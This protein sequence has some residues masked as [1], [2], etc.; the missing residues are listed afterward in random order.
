MTGVLR[1]S[2]SSPPSSSQE[3][4]KVIGVIFVCLG[5]ICMLRT[6][7]PLA[8]PPSVIPAPSLTRSN[9]PLQH[10]APGRS[11]AAEAVF[12]A[13]VKDAGLESSFDVDSCGTGGGNPS[14]YEPGGWSYH[15]GEMSDRRMKVAADSRG[16]NIV[17]TSRPLKPEDVGRFDYIVGMDDSNLRELVTPSFIPARAP[18][19]ATCLWLTLHAPLTLPLSR[20]RSRSLSHSLSL[21]RTLPF[22]S[23]LSAG[24]IR[25]AAEAWGVP[26]GAAQVQLMSE[27]CAKH[28][29]SS[30]PDPYYGGPQGF[31]KALDLLDDACDGLL[32]FIRK[33]QGV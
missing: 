21:P 2:S 27:F 1:A 4:E 25:T 9:I 8:I 17:S 5:N 13:R 3:K 16:I 26:L 15:E 30:V 31:D 12:K 11:P 19:N 22:R 6:P 18:R 28:D 20:S 29:V 10:P 14:W 23:F 24:A 7:R 32:A 33:E